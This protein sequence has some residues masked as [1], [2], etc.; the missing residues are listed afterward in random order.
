MSER[1]ASTYRKGQFTDAH[2]LAL[3]IL[4]ENHVR[5]LAEQVVQCFGYFDNQ[6]RPISYKVDILVNDPR[7][8]SGVIE[9]EGEGSNSKGNDRR[10]NHLAMQHLWVEHVPNKEAKNVMV[11][12][13]KH[14]R[15][16]D[17]YGGV[18]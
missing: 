5:Y 9:I 8:S 7:Y 14:K 17:D 6:G 18:Y 16:V 10:D 13:G 12:L 4:S 2:N 11:Y 3:A 1:S 15:K